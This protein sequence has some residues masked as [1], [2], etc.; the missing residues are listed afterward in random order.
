MTAKR[1]RNPADEPRLDD[2]SNWLTQTMAHNVLSE[3]L[4]GARGSALATMELTERLQSGELPFMRKSMIDPKRRQRGRASFW[5][6]RSLYLD[7]GSVRFYPPDQKRPRNHKTRVPWAY[8]VWKPDID[9]I[10]K[11]LLNQ[12]SP[13]RS[14]GNTRI[15][16]SRRSRRSPASRS[17]ATAA[18]RAAGTAQPRQPEQPEPEQLPQPIV[19]RRRG[20]TPLQLTDEEIERGKAHCRSM[21]EESAAW[22][23]QVGIGGA[24][25]NIIRKV[26]TRLKFESWQSVKR[27][28]I[29]PVMEE[30]GLR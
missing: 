12:R 15:D 8:Y 23:D 5:R 16:P 11:L 29:W 24:A 6:G 21:L 17:G 3:Q 4:I 26:L 22:I 1:K 27:K 28:I 13:T 10:G 19:K 2:D 14:R 20:G 25:Q 18:T 30:R 7:D 9:R